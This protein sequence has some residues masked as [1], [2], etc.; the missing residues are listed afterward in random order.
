MIQFKGYENKHYFGPACGDN[1]SLHWYET[2]VM[3]PDMIR[4]ELGRK[5]G[6]EVELEGDI[7]GFKG[8]LKPHQLK[9]I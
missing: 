2:K 8:M 7:F 3:N 5:E 4:M 6:I 9:R 1:T